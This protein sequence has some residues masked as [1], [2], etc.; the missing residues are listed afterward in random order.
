MLIYVSLVFLLFVCVIIVFVCQMDQ[1]TRLE[2]DVEVQRRIVS[3]AHR[4]ATDKSTNK[5]VRKKRHR[6]YEAAAKRLGQ[7]EQRL[8]YLKHRGSQPDLVS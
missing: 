7:V 6:D 5:S 3:A 8:L 2:T 4:L 1:I